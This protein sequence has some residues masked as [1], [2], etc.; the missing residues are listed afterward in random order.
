VLEVRDDL[1]SYDDPGWHEHS[2]ET[3]AKKVTSK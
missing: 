2:P 1:T 3:L